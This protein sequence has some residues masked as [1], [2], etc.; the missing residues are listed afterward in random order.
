MKYCPKCARGYDDTLYYCLQDGSYLTERDPEDTIIKPLP[1]TQLF[2]SDAQ[3]TLRDVQPPPPKRINIG[4]NA[5]AHTPPLR[6]PEKSRKSWI[7]VL[8]IGGLIA[9]S[10]VALVGFLQPSSSQPGTSNTNARAASTPAPSPTPPPKVRLSIINEIFELSSAEN[11]DITFTVPYSCRNPRVMGGFVVTNGGTI[12]LYLMTTAQFRENGN[13]TGTSLKWIREKNN[14]KL[15]HSV[16]SG[17][18]YITF[19]GWNVDGRT[20]TVAAEFYVECDSN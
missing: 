3:K 12:D 15:N 8:L 1:P 9:I 14:S 10:G 17:D 5:A 18:Y 4:V 13:T 11:R 2:I 16:S 20:K 6:K 7:V 19:V